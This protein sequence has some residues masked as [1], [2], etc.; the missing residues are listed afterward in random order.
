[1][2]PSN[3]NGSIDPALRLDDPND[4]AMANSGMVDGAGAPPPL[5]P[6]LH[7]PTRKDRTLHEFLD[8]MEEYA[9]IVSPVPSR[10]PCACTFAQ[11][12]SLRRR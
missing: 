7:P 11:T 8:S 9:P 5:Q 3:I 6:L 10:W 4:I 12:A 2:S 1:M